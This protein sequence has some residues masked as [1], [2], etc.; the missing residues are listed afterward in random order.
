[1][2]NTMEVPE[3]DQKKNSRKKL[4]HPIVKTFQTAIFRA[5]TKTKV[6]VFIR[7]DSCPRVVVGKLHEKGNKIII[8]D[9][10]NTH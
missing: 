7:F 1:M 5:F 2:V 3:K 6:L 9:F 8:V 4:K 10:R